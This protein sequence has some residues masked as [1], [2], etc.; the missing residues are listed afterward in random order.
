M[1]GDAAGKGGEHQMIVDLVVVASDEIAH[2]ADRHP[3][4]ASWGRLYSSGS[5]STTVATWIRRWRP[6][7][8]STRHCGVAARKTSSPMESVE[9]ADGVLELRTDSARI[10]RGR[11]ALCADVRTHGAFPQGG[12]SPLLGGIRLRSLP[13]QRLRSRAE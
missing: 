5:F 7:L 4:D 1:I 6:L 11:A 13:G 8:R 9:R 2:P 3:V 10:V 12:R